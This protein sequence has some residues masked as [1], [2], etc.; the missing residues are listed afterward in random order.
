MSPRQLYTAAN[1]LNKT[2]TDA[3]KCLVLKKKKINALDK[4]LWYYIQIFLTQYAMIFKSP[5]FVYVSCT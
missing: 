1:M 2:H 3:G 5:S 4:E